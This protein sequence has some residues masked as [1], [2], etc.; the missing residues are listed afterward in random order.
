MEQNWLS[1]VQPRF[2]GEQPQNLQESRCPYDWLDL[3]V[4]WFCFVFVFVFFSEK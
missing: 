3:H 2:L 1:Q 4:R